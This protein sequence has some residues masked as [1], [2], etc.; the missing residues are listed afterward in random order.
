MMPKNNYVE[1]VLTCGSYQQA[2]DI[3]DALLQKHLVACVEFF[4]IKSKFWWQKGIETADEI[5]LVMQSRDEYFA[6]A[7]RI[8][9]KLHGYDTFVMH[10][11]PL[12]H[13]SEAA[14]KWLKDTLD[15][16]GLKNG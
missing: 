12:T 2:Q 14:K 9:K 5:K 16:R 4:P 11:L 3:A 13:T 1:L 6:E 7:E 8:V 10:A 15:F